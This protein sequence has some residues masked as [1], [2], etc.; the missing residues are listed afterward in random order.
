MDERILIVYAGRYGSTA[1]VGVAIGQELGQCG[2]TVEVCPAKDVTEIGSYDAVIVGSAIYYGKWLPEAVKF[3]EMHREVLSRM[4]LAYFLTCL[5]LTRVPEE[6]G[7]DASVYLDP[8][9]GN[10]PQVEGKLI[11]WEKGHLLSGF[12]D[13]VQKRRPRSI[14]SALVCSEAVWTTVS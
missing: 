1:E 12:M 7:R 5:E 3:V 11:M 4:P 10:P 8:L 14:L 13:S 2:A 9:L 6:K